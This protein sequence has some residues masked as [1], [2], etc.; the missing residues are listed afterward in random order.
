MKFSN[1]FEKMEVLFN[2]IINSNIF[3]IAVILISFIMLFKILKKLSSK[4]IGIIIYLI[5][6]VL[7]GLVIFEGNE[8]LVNTGNTLIDKL[9]LDF[10]FPS[11]YV[12]LFISV[13]SFVIFIYTYFNKFISKTYK[14]ITNTYYLIFNFIF[15]LLVSVIANNNINIFDKLSLF[16]NNESLVLLEL[17]TLLF[18]LYLVTMVLVY[19]TNLIIIFVEDRKVSNYKYNNE[20]VISNP[21]DNLND[22]KVYAKN[23]GVS[24][25]ELVQNIGI[26]TEEKIDL[27]PELN[28]NVILEKNI[29]KIDL[30]PEVST[31]FEFINKDLFG[32]N[33]EE[34][35]NFIDFNIIDK[36]DSD[37]LTIND[38][39]KFS[40]MLKVV[41][42]NSN[43]KNLSINDILNK[44]LLNDYSYEEYTKFEKILN[45]CLN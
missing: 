1:L 4:K 6:V 33:L 12:Y 30:V 31:R 21:I 25:Q 16:G 40:D 35:L 19:F 27:I 28:N 7:L 37:K 14:M 23:T 15:V 22:N 44:V 11:V 32:M 5:E 9:F 38:Y 2:L 41:I 34:K 17:S 13:V 45:S 42:K 39:K 20:L 24:F 26:N 18:L 29:K 10:Y 3:A 36:K 8:I 43:D